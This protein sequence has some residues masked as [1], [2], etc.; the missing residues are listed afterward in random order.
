MI[1]RGDHT[2]FLRGKRLRELFGPLSWLVYPPEDVGPPG[3]NLLTARPNILRRL[4]RDLQITIGKRAIK[5][6]GAAW[7]STRVN[8]IPTS[9]Q[10][11]IDSA[12]Q[13]NDGRVGLRLSDGS[14]RTVDHVIAA[15]GFRIDIAKYPFL[16][17]ELVRRITVANGGYPVL[18]RGFESSVPGLHFVG[19]PAAWSYG[20]LMRFVSGTWFA[21]RTLARRI[22]R[23]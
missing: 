6:A 19:A 21:S 13:T 11:E 17:D 14:E 20:P 23:R 10:L 9:L 1:V 22:A 8:G 2:R 5:P 7:L 3:I 18:G 16:G 15:T 12:E 4:P